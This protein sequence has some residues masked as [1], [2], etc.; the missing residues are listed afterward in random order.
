MN[1]GGMSNETTLGKGFSSTFDGNRN[2]WNSALLCN[3]KT[4]FFKGQ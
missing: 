4:P 1:G 2:Q 3:D